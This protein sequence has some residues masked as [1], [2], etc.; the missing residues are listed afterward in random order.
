MQEELRKT[1]RNLQNREVQVAKMDAMGRRIAEITDLLGQRELRMETQMR[2]MCAQ[3]QTMNVTWQNIKRT[4][5]R[6][7]STFDILFRDTEAAL[8]RVRNINPKTQ[9][10]Y[11]QSHGANQLHS[12][13]KASIDV[14]C[15]HAHI[16]NNQ[17][18]HA[19]DVQHKRHQK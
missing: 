10:T 18:K 9:G 16:T 19:L 5:E 4:T 12:I 11:T 1:E 15:G 8:T 13:T 14:R 7:E 2:D 3:I 6:S 17:T